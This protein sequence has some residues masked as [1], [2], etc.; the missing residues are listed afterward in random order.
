M[1]CYKMAYIT[2]QNHTASIF[3]LAVC[4]DQIG[5]YNCAIKYF[6]LC[7]KLKPMTFQAFFGAALSNAKIGLY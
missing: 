7:I 6:N 2:F 3:N 4:Y 1:E 5:K